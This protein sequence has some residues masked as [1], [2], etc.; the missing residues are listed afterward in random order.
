MCMNNYSVFKRLAFK[1][2][3][4]IM[5]DMSIY[6]GSLAPRMADLFQPLNK[7]ENHNLTIGDLSWS[8][9]VGLAAGFDKN[10]KAIQFF[11]KSGFGAIEVGTITKK[12]QIGNPKPRIWRH[13][14]INSVQN[15]MGFPNAGYKEIL[16]NL[17]STDLSSVCLGA[18]IGKNKNTSEAKTPAEYAFLYEKFAPL[19][20]YLV[21]NISSPNTPG[22]RSFQ[23]KE[24]LVPLLQA[25]NEKRATTPKPLF[26]KVSPDMNQEDLNMLCE[27]SK[28]FALSGIIATNTTI[29]HD[30]G[31]GGL[32]GD[33]IRDISAKSRKI[34]CENLR[35][36]PGQSVIGV[37]GINCYQ[38]IKDFWKM[39]GGF[40]QIYTAF[41]FHGPK[42]LKDIAKEIDRDLKKYQLK[43]VQELYR[44]IKETD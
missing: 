16:S 39:G 38:D 31:K 29:D 18:N 42:L 32:S 43:N 22:L 19:A 17:E 24:L 33:Y 23:S 11:D 1:F 27:L 35:E 28:E 5:H 20:D 34:I 13:A 12:H 36:D 9:P 26:I 10:A 14:D 4:E 6:A 8:F 44:N 7:H 2:D 15:A 41:I 3:P 30:F 21:I 25:V 40:V 37:G